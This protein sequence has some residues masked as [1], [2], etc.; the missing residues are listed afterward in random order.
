[1]AATP[2]DQG[3]TVKPAITLKPKTVSVNGVTVSR[4]AIARETQN[5]PATKPV[6]AWQ[7]AARALVVRE[8]LLQ[9]ARRLAL[10]PAP[11]VDADG[12]RETDD[13]ALVRQLVAAEI[14]TPTADQA[15][16]RRYYDQNRKRF[17]SG[18]L[19]EVRHI[20]LAAPP[21][22]A[23][24]RQEGRAH[25][26]TLIELLRA[27]P[28]QFG[29]VAKMAS[30]CPSRNVGGNLGQIGPGQTVPE[31]EQA[32]AA[33]PVGA[34]APAPVESRYGFHIVMVDQRIEGR[35]L[36]FEMVETRIANW[37]DEKVRRTAIQQYI[38]I[39]AGKADIQGVDLAAHRSPLVQ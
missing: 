27:D 38:G 10:V 34:V 20:L 25:A 16:T 23:Q 7:Q 19:F 13:E 4:A 29:D 11:L 39:L 22:D 31:F 17:R 36:P 15:A 6:D 12:R 32:L 33:L 3:C 28:T 35:D 1:M 2:L 30:A 18:D 8:L 26:T 5:F 21:G 37:L 24:A 14:S 9:E